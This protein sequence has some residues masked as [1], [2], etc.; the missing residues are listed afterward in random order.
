MSTPKIREALLMRGEASPVDSELKT[1]NA[2]IQADERRSR[3]LTRATLAA[4]IAWFVCVTLMFALPVM[5]ARPANAPPLPPPSVVVSTMMLA[6]S[7]VVVMGAVFLPV[8]GVVLL[9]LAVFSRRATNISQLRASVAAIDAQLKA[10][11]ADR[12]IS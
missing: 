9:V 2:L 6:L 4:W 5:S 1:L 12:N 3:R 7:T 8:L 11:L 10:L